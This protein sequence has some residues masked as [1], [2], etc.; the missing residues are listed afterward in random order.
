MGAAITCEWMGDCT[1]AKDPILGGTISGTAELYET[2]GPVMTAGPGAC[3]A[4]R[5]PLTEDATHDADVVG[6]LIA[7]VAVGTEP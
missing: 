2:P 3:R 7:Q 1:S 5:G 4:L 6:N